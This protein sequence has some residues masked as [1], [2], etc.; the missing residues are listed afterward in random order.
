M[1]DSFGLV[2]SK[3][4]SVII[5]Q[6][7]KIDRWTLDTLQCLSFQSP[8]NYF[9]GRYSAIRMKN[10]V[11]NLLLIRCLLGWTKL[12]LLHLSPFQIFLDKVQASFWC[13]YRQA[14]KQHIVQTLLTSLTYAIYLPSLK[15]EQWSCIVTVKR[16]RVESNAGTRS[17]LG[18]RW[19][20][21]PLI[22]ARN[23]FPLSTKS[24]NP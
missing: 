6:W 21:A 10:V 18:S 8:F 9:F 19:S 15:I 5:P 1:R 24:P 4:I 22:Y 23:L 20:L 2:S 13:H 17:S 12:I 3:S 11:I 7:W 14:T 16:L